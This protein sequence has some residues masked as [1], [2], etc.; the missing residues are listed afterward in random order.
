ML[1]DEIQFLLETIN[2]QFEIICKYEEKIPEIELDILMDNVKKIYSKL[3]L[4]IRA[5]EQ[6][7]LTDIILPPQKSSN[8]TDPAPKSPENL[9]GTQDL[10]PEQPQKPPEKEIRLFKNPARTGK[11]GRSQ[12]PDLFSDRTSEFSEKLQEAR[13]QNIPKSRKSKSN[14]LKAMISINEKF[15]FINELFDGNLG[16]YNENIEAL[17]RFQDLNQAMEH[18]DLLR[19]KNL[20]NSES[21]AFL[22][23][24]ELLE[25][26]F[27]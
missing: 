23:L 1:I 6:V 24:R 7:L 12:A 4:V 25:K 9:P 5:N 27:G 14:D 17:G 20:W 8:F 26:R 16:E 3:Q 15:L 21:V 18:L 13:L 22:Q 19:K 2:E 10:V 11:P